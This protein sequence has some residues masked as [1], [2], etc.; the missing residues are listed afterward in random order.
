VFL[1]WRFFAVA[2]LLLLTRHAVLFYCQL[3]VFGILHHI[4]VEIF[5]NQSID[6]SSIWDKGTDFIGYNMLAIVENPNLV[7]I[8]LQNYE[9]KKIICK[10]INSQKH[11]S[12]E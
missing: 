6:F 4:I 11:N 5:K 12:S 7:V 1:F 8:P 9:S 10:E 3:G 2:F